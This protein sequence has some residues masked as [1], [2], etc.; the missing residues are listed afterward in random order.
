MHILPDTVSR[1]D[2]S[3]LASIVIPHPVLGP[4]L[5]RWHRLALPDGWLSGSAIAQAV[6][7]RVFDLPPDHGL[8]DIDLV[9]F[10]AAD[11]SEAGERAHAD[12]I[13]GLL[14]DLSIQADVINEARVH[15]WY[16]AQFGE[17]I[18]PYRSAEAAIATFPTTSAA[19]GIR[20]APSGGLEIV[21]PFGLS[22]LLAPIVRPNRVQATQAIYERK[23]RRWRALWPDLAMI[24]WAGDSALRD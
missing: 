1:E 15:L 5:E 13:G 22:D 14:S 3:T 2:V 9:Y 24:D 8:A 12:R 11:L 20:P 23:Q 6:W 7:N 18:A 19:V 4:V 10:D 17:A 16:E 21:A